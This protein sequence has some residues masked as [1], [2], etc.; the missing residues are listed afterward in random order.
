MNNIAKTQYTT[1][2][3]SALKIKPS[4]QYLD[5]QMQPGFDESEETYISVIARFWNRI[6]DRLMQ[7]EG[8]SEFLSGTIQGKTFNKAKGWQSL[9]MGSCLF[10]VS[11]AFIFFGR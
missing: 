5:P 4:E 3:S 6:I 10:A 2:G 8:V 7:M 11:I 9:L 1:V